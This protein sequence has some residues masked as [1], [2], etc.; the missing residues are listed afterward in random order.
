MLLLHMRIKGTHKHA[1]TEGLLKGTLAVR[2]ATS[3]LCRI[4]LDPSPSPPALGPLRLGK[5]HMSIPSHKK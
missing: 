4:P 3:S 2:L 1:I 5:G